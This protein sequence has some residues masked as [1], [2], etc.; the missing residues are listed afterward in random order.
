MQNP[1]NV[2]T[3]QTFVYIVYIS[4][5][6]I[7]RPQRYFLVA[8]KIKF[9]F[10]LRRTENRINIFRFYF[11]FRKLCTALNMKNCVELSKAF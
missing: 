2:N 4:V 11:N 9:L 3:M 6:T 5:N 8:R 7:S 10:T 1:H